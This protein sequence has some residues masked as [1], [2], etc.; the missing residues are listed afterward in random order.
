MIQQIL[1]EFEESYQKAGKT[2]KQMAEELGITP[3]HLCRVL[4]GKATA[5]V[6]LIDKMCEILLKER[7]IKKLW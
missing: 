5:S 3:Q 4:H 6:G 2:Q 1:R 7:G